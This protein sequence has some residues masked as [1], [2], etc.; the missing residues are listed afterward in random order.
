M[1]RED[2]LI[3]F[4]YD[5]VYQAV[6]SLCA[7]QKVKKPPQGHI[8]SVE[9]PDGDSS[10]VKIALFN[11]STQESAQVEYSRDFFAASLMLF[12]RGLG[13]PLPKTSHKSV[14]IRDGEVCLRIRIGAPA[15]AGS[16]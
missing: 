5:E 16:L 11:N 8:E 12:C 1:P 7:Q 15:E 6:Y 13:I 4:N 3:T 14:S 9:H 2:R 10:R